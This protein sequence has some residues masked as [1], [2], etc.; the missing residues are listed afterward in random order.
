M[1]IYTYTYKNIIHIE[2][3]DDVDVAIVVDDI[4]NGERGR[5]RTSNDQVDIC[6]NAEEII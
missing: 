1:H 5:E 4:D 6:V 3:T 2:D